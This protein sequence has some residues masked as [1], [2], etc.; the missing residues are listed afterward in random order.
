M[1]QLQH[2]NRNRGEFKETPVSYTKRKW[3]I[4]S[5]IGVYLDRWKG[6]L[7]FYLDRQLLGIAFK[8]TLIS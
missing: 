6:T 7:S 5:V 1:G 8:G 3:G 4:G 2:D